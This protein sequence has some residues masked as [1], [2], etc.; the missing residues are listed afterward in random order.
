MMNRSG[1]DVHISELFAIVDWSGRQAK[2]SRDMPMI[3]QELCKSSTESEC[4]PFAI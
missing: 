4:T 1:S 2:A 3:E